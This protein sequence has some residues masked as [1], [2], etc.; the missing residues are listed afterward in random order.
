MDFTRASMRCASPAPSMV[1]VFPPGAFAGR[2]LH[3]LE[4]ATF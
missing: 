1:I 2:G 3:P 4:S